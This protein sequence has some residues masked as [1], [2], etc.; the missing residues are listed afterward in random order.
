MNI[1][2]SCSLPYLL[3]L[4]RRNMM[5][6]G[7]IIK[8]IEE[9]SAKTKKRRFKQSAEIS[10]N[11]KDLNME[12]AENKLNLNILL[13]RGRNKEVNIGIFADGDMNVRAKK[14]SKFVLNRKELEE[15]SKK[16]RKM[17][18]FADLC[19]WFIAQPELMPTIGR[20]WG[21]ILG[22]RGKM[23]QPVPATA[24]LDAIVERLKNTVRIR[25]KKNPTVNVPVGTEDMKPEDLAE[26]I[27]AVMNGIERQIPPDKIRSVYFK[28]TMSHAIRLDR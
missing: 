11:F 15:Y 23:P 21:I 5:E 4:G 20:T 14:L 19:Y 9:L 16:R 26:N 24:D 28:T 12:S 2:R 7:E 1:F 3:V 10:I 13:P 27:L 17:R 6:K 8:R 18:K 22:P 25:S